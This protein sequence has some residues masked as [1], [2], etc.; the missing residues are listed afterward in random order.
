M[1]YDA[2]IVGAGPAGGMAARTLSKK[3]YRVLVLEK[4]KA[5]GQPV[6]CAE[7]ISH[8]A[9]EENGLAR[10]HEWIK[11]IVKGAR[12]VMPDGSHFFV[13]QK[14]YSIARDL[15]DSWLMNKAVDCGAELKLSCMANGVNRCGPGWSVNTD[16]GEFA[17][18]IL[19]GADGPSSNV[20]RW[21]GL[22]EKRIFARALEY[23]FDSRDFDYDEK[24]WLSFLLGAGWHGGSAWVFPRGNEWNIGVGG[25]GKVPESLARLLKQLGIDKE[26]TNRKIAGLV[27][28]RYKLTSLAGRGIM[29]AGDAA[30]TTNPIIGSGIRSALNSGRIAG[31]TACRALDSE[32]PELTQQYDPRMKKEPFL[33]PV[34]HLSAEHL[35]KW[36]DEDWNFL[37][38]M[39][40]G[41]DESALS[42]LEGTVAALK[43]PK[44][45][46]R[47]K[48]FMT[49]RKG[50]RLT[51]R[52]G[53]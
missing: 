23:T 32:K 52:Y 51:N 43:K 4:K 26:K 38:H 1:E 27:P 30:G 2:I 22:V 9:L 25:F 34:L 39:M 18:K 49:I 50:I 31:E 13:T 47:G 33:D 42:V 44:Y 41:R 28:Y 20:A 17:G 16:C 7:A 53:W 15:F 8:A 19:I 46:F 5:V 3:G 29:I 36:T 35:R 40:R 37:G 21:L 10:K 48:E 45:L 14:G 6:Q 11:Q 24:E 12:P